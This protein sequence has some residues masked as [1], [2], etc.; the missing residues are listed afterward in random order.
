MLLNRSA[1]PKII[2]GVVLCELAGGLGAMATASSV[3]DWYPTLIKPSWTP[4]SAV[5]GPVWIV[6]YAMMGVALG[7]VWARGLEGKREKRAFTWFGIQLALNVLWSVVFFGLQ[8]L[9]GGYAVIILLW[10]AIAA[11]IWVFSKISAPAGW[12]LVPYF[13]W[14]TFASTLNFSLVSYN[15]IR[16]GMQKMDSDPRN[17]KPFRKAPELRSEAQPK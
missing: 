6:L 11:T 10:L 1:W 14:V 12:L 8:S 7:L 2:I 16:P 4:P 9:I 5:F 3:R 13:L 15:F 17:G